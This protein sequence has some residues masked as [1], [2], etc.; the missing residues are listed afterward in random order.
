MIIKHSQGRSEDLAEL[1]DLLNLP[2]LNAQT[3]KQI[4]QQIRQ[5]RSGLKGEAEAAYQ[6]NFDYTDTPNWAVIHDLR[7]EHN[8]HAA[9]ID[10]LLINRLMEIYVCESKHFGEGV[11][12]NEHGE[13]SAFYQGRAYGIPSPLE[14]NNRHI[15]FLEKFFD[16]DDIKLPMRLG[17]KIKPRMYSLILIANSA[18]ISRPK[19]TQK[20]AGLDR[21]IKNEQLRKRIN[22]DAD[23]INLGAIAGIAKMISAQTLQTFAETLAQRHRPLKTDWKA[24]F[25]ITD[26][27]RPAAQQAA[28][29]PDPA[30]A[31]ETEP[32]PPAADKLF[33][34]ACKKTVTPAVAQYCRQNKTRFQGRV[35]CFNCQKTIRAPSP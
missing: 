33:C 31:T 17:L 24:R 28:P 22:Q 2:H 27:V 32:A 9:Q 16:S 25:G 5:I 13:F 11:S 30:A 19:N 10:H 1:N 26:P 14:Q 21:I 20:P 6:I 34:A 18:R 35:Y 8:G 3:K 29:D 7:L 23:E 12:V 4:D 15:R